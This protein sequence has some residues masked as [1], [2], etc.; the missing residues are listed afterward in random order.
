M[1]NVQWP[2][3]NETDKKSLHEGGPFAYRPVGTPTLTPQILTEGGH[4]CLYRRWRPTLRDVREFCVVDPKQM[5]G[6][7]TCCLPRREANPAPVA[8]GSHRLEE[9]LLHI[10]FAD[11]LQREVFGFQ[12]SQEPIGRAQADP[13]TVAG[14]TLG[15][16]VLGE[17]AEMLAELTVTE[18]IESATT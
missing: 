17:S 10:G 8:Y 7:S 18:T 6:S 11:H 2:V 4:R 12:P 16:Q 9:V 3:P 1:D 15:V 5:H 14:I 13:C